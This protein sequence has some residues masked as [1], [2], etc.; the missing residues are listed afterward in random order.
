MLFI[1]SVI[2]T[3]GYL[4]M[5]AVLKHADYKSAASF[6]RYWQAQIK[7]HEEDEDRTLPGTLTLTEL[8]EEF[9]KDGI[10]LCYDFR[11]QE[12]RK[13]PSSLRSYYVPELVKFG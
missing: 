7:L 11:T 2:I 10:N 5:L 3:I 9:N 4:L 12:I 6:A 8:A 13:I 1:L